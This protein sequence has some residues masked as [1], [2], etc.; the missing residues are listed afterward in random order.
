MITVPKAKTIFT[1]ACG[2]ALL[3]AAGFG[4]AGSAQASETRGYVVSWFY[5]ATYAD[6]SHCPDGLNPSSELVFRRILKEAGTPPEKVEKL[7]EDFPNSMYFMAG[8]RGKI[9][10][11][12]TDV[13]LNPTSVPDPE[14][15]LA[16]GTKSL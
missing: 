11:K 13:Y 8:R 3:A 5:Y 1:R 2:A 6:E 16:Q 15:K 14:L 7:L 4:A 9:D 10:G 12:P